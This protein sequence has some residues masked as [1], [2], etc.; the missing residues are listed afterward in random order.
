[1]A[2]L[3]LVVENTHFFTYKG[4]NI[5]LDVNSG[6][7]HVLD[8]AAAAV[9]DVELKGG[10]FPALYAKFGKDIVDEAVA[11]LKQLKDE[12]LLASSGAEDIGALFE[13]PA[14]V[15]SLCLHVSH[16]CN[17]R[18]RYCFAGTGRFG[19]Q[20]Q[21]MTAA[22]A[23]AAV[24]LIL[25]ASGPRQSCE[26]DFF[27][28]EPLMNMPVV[29]ETVQYARQAAEAKGKQVNLTLTTNG[30][31]LDQ[32]VR[33][34]LAEQQIKLVLSL[35]GRKQVND[36]MRPGA[37]G[38][39]SYADI[40]PNLRAMVDQLDGQGYYLRGTYTRHNLDFASDVAHMLECGFRELSVE[41]VV[42]PPQA[43]YALTEDDYPCLAEEYDRLVDL[44][45]EYQRRGEPFN[46]FHFNVNLE[47][48]PCL[49]K[50]LRG[51]GAGFEYLAV[52]P[53]GE[54]YPCHQFVGE[55]NFLLG[56]VH[57]GIVNNQVSERFRH[58]HIYNKQE[59]SGC[60]ARHF[61]SGGCNA[62]AY[63]Q[64]NDLLK[65]YHVGCLVQKKRLECAIYLEV[66][67]LLST[68]G[69]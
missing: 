47:Q 58:A 33:D 23:R 66:T 22:T 60:W 37:R 42:A 30:V 6:A 52:T 48:G 36:Y 12:G 2:K 11:Q 64:N 13:Q 53:D 24:D 26:I 31:L 15:K 28:G 45:L 20:R 56:D 9:L 32:D 18:C 21:L 41:P 38:G 27:G 14:Y 67:K 39:G 44:Y 10:D 19:G 5:L 62:N 57:Q 43:D 8:D 3:D 61:C 51:C 69:E 34:Y 55:E 68:G 63:H 46:F 65:P 25:D 17:L 35:D 54:L 50:R 4:I 59:C 29:K 49:P 40:M 16:D 7:V 1:M